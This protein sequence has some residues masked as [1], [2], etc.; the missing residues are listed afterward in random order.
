MTDF[1]ETE[2]AE[3]QKRL[4]VSQ[5]KVQTRAPVAEKKPRRAA[6]AEPAKK[7]TPVVYLEPD[8][9]SEEDEPESAEASESETEPE[10]ETESEE[11]PEPI[12]PPRK[13]PPTP[14]VATD[15]FD[16]FMKEHGAQQK[17][18]SSL[19]ITSGGIF[20]SRTGRKWF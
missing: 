5:K 10:S 7:K 13:M 2:I 3:F 18:Q 19:S 14:S 1:V 16:A 20:G 17:P 12:P 11:A 6:L 4:G 15:S 9:P 8:E